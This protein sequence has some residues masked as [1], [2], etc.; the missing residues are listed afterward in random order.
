MGGY[1]NVLTPKAKKGIIFSLNA[2]IKLEVWGAIIAACV[3]NFF[4]IGGSYV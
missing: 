4:K 3:S 2:H 1:P